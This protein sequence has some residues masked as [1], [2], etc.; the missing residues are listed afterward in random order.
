MYDSDPWSVNLT[1]GQVPLADENGIITHYNVTYEPKEFT[2]TIKSMNTSIEVY[3]DEDI[4]IWNHMS[5]IEVNCSYFK[6]NSRPLSSNPTNFTITGLFPFTEYEVK[7][8][9]CTKIGCSEVST[10]GNFKTGPTYPSCSI[11]NITMTNTSSESLMVKWVPLTH[12]CLHGTLVEHFVMV[13]E[14]EIQPPL[15]NDNRTSTSDELLITDLKKYWNY[16]V[17]LLPVNQI[18]RGPPS[19]IVWAMTDE[20]GK[21]FYIFLL[22]MISRF[23]FNIISA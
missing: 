13:Y 4:L 3:P 8:Y 16:S 2:D 21:R 22:I 12:Q 10:T 7:V 20:D 19:N 6:N 15:Y 1:V 18:G 17:V 5:N 23:L 11:Q 9:P 14:S